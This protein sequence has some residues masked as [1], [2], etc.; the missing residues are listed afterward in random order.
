MLVGVGLVPARLAGDHEG[1]P[2]AVCLASI[3]AQP[4]VLP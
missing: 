1:R 2:Y 3:S 4:F